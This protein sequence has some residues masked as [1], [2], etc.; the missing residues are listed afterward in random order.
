MC[1]MALI[2]LAA[3]RFSTRLASAAAAADAIAPVAPVARIFAIKPLRRR[4]CRARSCP[5]RRSCGSFRRAR[6]CPCRCTPGR[7]PRP[8]PACRAVLHRRDLA[9][10]WKVVVSCGASF[11][12]AGE[13]LLARAQA[14]GKRFEVHLGL[15]GGG[16]HLALF[17]L[18]VVL[19]V[20]A[21]HGESGEVV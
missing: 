2:G 13:L 17:L 6:S 7:C 3:W 15:L 10:C 1:A 5:C 21:E 12:L 16:E 20:F 19:D 14:L 8:C 11:R 18:D 9:A 4:R